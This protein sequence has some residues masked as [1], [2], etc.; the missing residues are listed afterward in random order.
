MNAVLSYLYVF[1]IGQ[2]VKIGIT[3]DPAKRFTQ[4]AGGYNGGRRP[5]DAE[6]DCDSL[7][8]VR[9]NLESEQTIH[10]LLEPFRIDG[11][12]WYR[13]EGLVADWCDRLRTSHRYSTARHLAGL[14]RLLDSGRI[15]GEGPAFRPVTHSKA[16]RSTTR[17]EECGYA[18][19]GR[20]LCSRCRSAA[21]VKF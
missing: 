2:Y 3:T 16:P 20:K 14:P 17:C 6:G 8:V 4:H 19:W 12:E 11:S 9:S 15:V 10:S 21:P 1:R 18:A 5:A 7:L 13:N